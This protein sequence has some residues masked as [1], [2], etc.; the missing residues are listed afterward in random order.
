MKKTSRFTVKSRTHKNKSPKFELNPEMLQRRK[1]S[2]K[3]REN[4]I[5]PRK[6]TL[7]R[8]NM[9]RPIGDVDIPNTPRRKGRF[10]EIDVEDDPRR[11]MSNNVLQKQQMGLT[12]AMLKGK[13]R[14]LKHRNRSQSPRKATVRRYNMRRPY[15]DVD[16]P[17]TPRRQG[18]Y[19][20]IDVEPTNKAPIS[21]TLTMKIH[22]K[23]YHTL[24]MTKNKY[25][26]NMFDEGERIIKSSSSSSRKRKSR[27]S[28]K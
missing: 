13:R 12:A 17:N 25:L 9:Y 16:I 4:H 1:H 8:Y 21:P 14:V 10:R 3:N 28:R 24:H 5:S 18:R 22:N 19:N 15:D 2:L 20:V 7:R 6:A 11:F 26:L 23:D 27:K